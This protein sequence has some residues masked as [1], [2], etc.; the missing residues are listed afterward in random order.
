MP[1]LPWR[2]RNPLEMVQWLS[3]KLEGTGAVVVTEERLKELEQAA[4]TLD[5]HHAAVRD[6]DAEAERLNREVMRLYL[7]LGFLGWFLIRKLVQ[8]GGANAEG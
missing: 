4:A 1:R 8:E 7:I 5:E 3:K 2:K 6:L